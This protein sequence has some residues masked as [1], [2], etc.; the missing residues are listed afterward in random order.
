MKLNNLFTSHMVLPMN[1][2]FLVFGEGKGIAKVV[3]NGIERSVD[4]DSDKWEMSFPPMDYG[5]PY[6]MTV[7]LNGEK[8]VLDDIYIGKVYL[9]A[10]QSNMQFKIEESTTKPED[11]KPTSKLRLFS[12]RRV[13]DG[14]YFFPEDGWIVADKSDVDKWPAI[15]YLV[16]EYLSNKTDIAIGAVTCY[17][18]ASVIESWVPKGTFESVG[19]NIPIGD[20]HKDHVDEWFGKWNKDSDL[21]DFTFRKIIP[22]SFNGVIWYQGESDSSVPEGK[23]YD[24]ELCELIKVWR[25][26]LRDNSLLFIVIQIADYDERDDEGWR[27]VQ[28]AQLR[29][30]KMLPN[31]KTVVCRDVCESDDIHPPTK[32]TVSDRVVKAI[33]DFE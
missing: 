9:F 16:S 21:Y 17:Q 1:K 31:V 3:F 29:A 18:G 20:R 27:F 22:F 4:T 19:I 32:T 33:C 2:E 14:E 8:T 7:I 23:V 24:K 11:C 12:T 28:E 30:E 5:G 26:D 25:R 15:P 6:E 10:G 13:E